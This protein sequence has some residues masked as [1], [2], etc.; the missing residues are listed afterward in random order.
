MIIHYLL[1][2]LTECCAILSLSI[3][4]I[5]NYVAMFNFCE[6]LEFLDIGNVGGK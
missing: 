1:I 6:E 3:K 4:E 5:P 2:E